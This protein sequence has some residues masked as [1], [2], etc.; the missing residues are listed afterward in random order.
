MPR[1]RLEEENSLIVCKKGTMS[2]AT[3]LC[4]IRRITVRSLACSTASTNTCGSVW[5]ATLLA[6]LPLMT[7]CLYSVSESFNGRMRAEILNSE[8]F[9]N[10]TEAHVLI[11][12]W[13]D[14]YNFI[15]PHSGLGF[16]PPAP[17]SIQPV[18]NT[19]SQ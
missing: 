5:S 3:T 2:G 10:L 8:I 13:K 4:Q 11:N 15:R 7:C 18:S 12:R 9:F 16:K 17:E 19:N 14:F 6:A 1:K